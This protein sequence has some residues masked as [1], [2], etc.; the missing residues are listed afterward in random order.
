MTSTI[1]ETKAFRAV[2]PSALSAYAR[3]EG[4]VKTEPY[5]D[6]SDVYVADGLPEI[7]LP[8]TQQIGDYIY[9]V[10]QLIDIFARVAEMDETSVYRSLIT[11][12][13]DVVR[14]R[15]NIQYEGAVGL[16]DGISLVNGMRDMFLAAACSLKY[17]RPVY[18]AGANKEANDYLRRMRLGQTEY[19]SFVVTMLTPVISPPTQQPLDTSFGYD[20]DPSERRVTIRLAEALAAVRAATEMAAVGDTDAFSQTIQNGVSANLCESVAQM[21]EPFPSMDLSLTWARTRPRETPRSTVQFIQDDVPILAEAA[22]AFKSR[23]PNMDVRLF[24]FVQRLKRDKSDVGG[25]I[26]LRA[27]I[28]GGDRI[29]SVTAVLNQQDYSRSVKAHDEK[30]SVIAEGDLERVGQRWHLLNPRIIEV[31]S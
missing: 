8:R 9:V 24:G 27:S 7:I 4:W 29:E 11:A 5:G 17:P 14:A 20:D 12:D 15:A 10:S 31:I 21:V 13:R 22:R 1:R 25:T 16:E 6:H 28:D 23:E 18:R 3:S 19:G 30:A 26:T 2:S